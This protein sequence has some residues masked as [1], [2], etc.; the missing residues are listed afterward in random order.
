METQQMMELLLARMNSSVKEHMQE[1]TARMDTN[2]ANLEADR[3]ADQEH[4]QDMLAR[5]DADRK[6]DREEMKGDLLARLEAKMDLKLKETSKEIKSGEAQMRAIV[7]AWIADMMEN[8]KERTAFQEATDA[9]PKKMEP[10][11]VEKEAVVE[12]QEIPNKEV[13]VDSLSAC[14]NKRTA[15]QGVMEANPEKVRPID[16]AIAI[17]AKMEAMDLKANP[18]EMESK[19][20]HQ[21]VPTEGA[22]VKSSGTMKKRHRG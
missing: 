9:N 5:M 22:T 19:S 1:M 3:K 18:E 7:N 13:V 14:R 11:P 12:Q 10:N 2:Q 16:R 8:R 20:A 21:E 4:M 15:C 17:L 6:D